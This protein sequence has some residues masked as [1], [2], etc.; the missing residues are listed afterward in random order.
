MSLPP[1]PLQAEALVELAKYL[2]IFILVAHC[3]YQRNHYSENLVRNS[4]FP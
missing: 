4:P 3:A 2:F 1:A